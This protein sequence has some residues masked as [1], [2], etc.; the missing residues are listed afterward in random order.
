M[1]TENAPAPMDEDEP[2]TPTQPQEAAVSSLGNLGP[3]QFT[4][5]PKQFTT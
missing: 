2:T 1:E 5:G 4:V 3:K